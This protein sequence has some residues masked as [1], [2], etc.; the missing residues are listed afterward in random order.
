M[1]HGPGVPA[2]LLA[3]LVTG[4]AGSGGGAGRF[5]PARG[6][7]ARLDAAAPTPAGV[8][9]EPPAP[10]AGTETW[11]PA[12]PL[13]Y[14]PYLAAPRQSRTAV[15][16]EIPL[17]DGR[18]PK[19]ENS[20]GFVRSIVRW[21]RADA[22]GAGTEV[23]FEAGVFAR[24]DLKEDTD[25]DASDWRFG[26]PVVHRDGDLA[27]KIHAYHMTSHLGDEYMDR[28]GAEPVAYHLE[29]LSGGVSWDASAGT[30]VYGEAGA[31]L[32]AGTST[33]SGRVQ[34]GWEWVG[35][36]GTSGLAPF[37]ALDLQARREQDWTPAGTVAMGIARGRALRLALE[38]FHGRDPQTQ[39]LDD[40]THYLSVGLT[41]DL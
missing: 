5:E 23:Q 41:M 32:Y 35:R 11:F 29:E 31:A 3:L 34:A 28:T 33:E 38:Y 27:W 39:F 22:P 30:R 14:D 26:F 13:L 21:T 15:K 9:G 7:G 36:K 6:P 10:G 17:G 4:C 37:L 24:F 25:M 20:L 12:G 18:N 16:A 8:P 1:P 19:L 2:V 40:R